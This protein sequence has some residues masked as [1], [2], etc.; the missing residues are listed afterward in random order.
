MLT[1]TNDNGISVKP[2]EYILRAMDRYNIICSTCNMS[3]TT[4]IRS[5]VDLDGAV[6]KVTDRIPSTAGRGIFEVEDGFV[7]AGCN[8]HCI[9]ALTYSERYR[10]CWDQSND[11]NIF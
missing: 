8:R 3:S 2:L 4:N 5:S 11:K 9:Y 6:P 1:S 10:D 7:D